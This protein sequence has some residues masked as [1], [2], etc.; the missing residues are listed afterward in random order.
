MGGRC[1]AFANIFRPILFS[2]EVPTAHIDAMYV[3]IWYVFSVSHGNIPNLGNILL[4]Q[5]RRMHVCVGNG[6]ARYHEYSSLTGYPLE[7]ST[8]YFFADDHRG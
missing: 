3:F 5:C 2:S 1:S 7:G 8:R 4:G 6:H